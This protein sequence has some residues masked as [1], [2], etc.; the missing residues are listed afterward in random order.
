[1]K[2]E[3]FDISICEDI[4]EIKRIVSA[5][6]IS[7]SKIQLDIDNKNCVISGSSE[8]PYSVTLTSCTCGDFI[9]RRSPCKHMYRLAIDLGVISGIP[10][11]KKDSSFDADSE[12]HKFL[13]AYRNGE[14]SG[15]KFIKIAEAIR[16]GK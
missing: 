2:I 11:L 16:K 6:K 8:T 3:N 9:A 1:M 5:Q 13:T 4:E 12:I 15:E 7:A 14:I 10:S